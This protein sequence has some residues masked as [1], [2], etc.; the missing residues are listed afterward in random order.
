MINI[1]QNKL[2]SKKFKNFYYVLILA[3][4]IGLSLFIGS[5]H[6]PWADETQAWLIARDTSIHDLFTKFL[7]SDGHPALWHLILKFFQFIGLQYQYFYIIPIIFS[8]LGIGVFL[9]KSDFPWYIKLLLPFTYFIFYQY[10]IVARG[11]CLLFLLLC[12]LACYW[13]KKFEKVDIFTI[14]LILLINAEAYTFMFSG[15]V[16]II[17]IYEYIKKRKNN[18]FDKNTALK[19]LL[20][21]FII[22]FAFIITV[23]YV[24]PRS[25]AGN[26]KIPFYLSDAFFTDFTYTNPVI[27]IIVS[28]LI[29]I[30]FLVFIYRKNYKKMAQL[31]LFLAPVI[32]FFIIKYMNY[33]HVGI[34][35]LITIFAFWIHKLANNK[36]VNLFLIVVCIMQIPQCVASSIDDY[37]SSYCSAEEIANIIKEYDY[38]N[39]DILGIDFW[40]NSVNFYFDENIFYNQY[41]AGFFY[42][43]LENPY[44]DE[45]YNNYYIKTNEPDIIVL[46]CHY[47]PNFNEIPNYNLYKFPSYIFMQGNKHDNTYY[48]Y[49]RKDIDKHTITN[50]V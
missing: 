15:A 42:L 43:N 45:N 32:I 50:N 38:E 4:F 17:F 9:F 41:D 39:L 1:L 13:D 20:N 27:K 30:Y 11:Y 7:H 21:I 23:L 48:L 14:I 37:N 24:Y 47:F 49:I 2:N 31:C 33:Y 46:D 19:I 28:I 35:L 16:F 44:Y 5:H 6:E 10:T 8:S 34:I 22:A 40:S 12:L 25:N 3:A 26:L 36:Y 29:V 18:E